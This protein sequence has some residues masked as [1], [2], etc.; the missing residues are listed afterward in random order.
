MSLQCEH[1]VDCTKNAIGEK[2]AYCELWGGWKNITLGDC[3]GN[4][5]AQKSL[6]DYLKEEAQK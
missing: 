4:C 5:E 1:C 6:A 2:V 3:F